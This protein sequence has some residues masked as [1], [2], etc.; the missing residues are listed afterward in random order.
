MKK[1][2]TA[3]RLTAAAVRLLK[4]IAENMGLSQTGVIETLVRDKARELD[5][6]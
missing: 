1:I 4:L 3:F 5:I 2:S 6:K